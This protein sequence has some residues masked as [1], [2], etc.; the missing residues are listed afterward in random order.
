MRVVFTSCHVTSDWQNP[1]PHTF[2]SIFTDVT[3]IGTCFLCQIDSDSKWAKWE[4]WIRS[5]SLQLR[6]NVRLLTWTPC[7]TVP[8][9][10]CGEKLGEN[11]VTC[12]AHIPGSGMFAAC[13]NVW[14]TIQKC[15]MKGNERQWKAI[16]GNEMQWKAMKG[17]WT[18][19]IHHISLSSTGLT[20]GLTNSGK[21]MFEV[22]VLKARTGCFWFCEAEALSSKGMTSNFHLLRFTSSRCSRC[23]R[24][25]SSDLD[26]NR[27]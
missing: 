13:S 22:Q 16:K 9:R 14:K 6:E 26:S 21:S 25:S 12:P 2:T 23:S 8:G 19:R 4:I 11:S 17:K 20:T 1:I 7:K 3:I 18:H 5:A 24:C 15:L 10:V 27:F